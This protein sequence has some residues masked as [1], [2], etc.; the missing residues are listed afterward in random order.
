MKKKTQKGKTNESRG[1]EVGGETMS[2]GGTLPVV[3]S[4]LCTAP[5]PLANV[6]A[7]YRVQLSSTTD[8]E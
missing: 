3:V 1:Q 7:E 5:A 6:S 4:V 8:V 2:R